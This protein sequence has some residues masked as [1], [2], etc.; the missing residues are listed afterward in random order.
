MRVYQFRHPGEW[1][2]EVREPPGP[3]QAP[4]RGSEPRSAPSVMRP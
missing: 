1:A 4:A 3:G 2:G